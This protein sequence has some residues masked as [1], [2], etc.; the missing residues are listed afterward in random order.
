MEITILKINKIYIENILFALTFILL[1][2]G[3]LNSI[4]GNTVGNLSIIFSFLLMFLNLFYKLTL[5]KTYNK[6]LISFFVISLF[7]ILISLFSSILNYNSTLNNTLQFSAIILF[8]ISFSTI[9]WNSFKINFSYI[10]SFIYVSL[11]LIYAAAL[12]KFSQF[13]SIYPNSNLVGAYGFI[14]L[15]FIILRLN[16][17][18][19]KVIPII[20]ILLSMLLIIIS[21]TRSIILSI[22]IVVLIFLGWEK[23]TKSMF[24]ANFFFVMYIGILVFTIVIYAK[25]PDYDFY[26]RLESWMIENTGKSIM[27]GRLEIWSEVMNL[28][29]QKPWFGYGPDVKASTIISLNASPHNIYINTMLQVGIIGLI[30]FVGILYSI[31]YS[32]ILKKDEITVKISAAFYFG[33][34]FHQLFEITLTQNQLSIGL[35]QWLIFSVGFNNIKNPYK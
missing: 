14:A 8:F 34:I 7:Y 30:L 9:E 16:Y 35:F 5:K 32:Y 15:F 28:I 27:S 3:T 25:L 4:S 19:N 18:N 21:D 1:L 6:S 24:R 22:I 17:S 10:M 31:F 2:F 29:S 26:P 20:G 33:I 23:I 11:N 13:M 12:G